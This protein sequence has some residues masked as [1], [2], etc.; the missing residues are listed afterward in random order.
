MMAARPSL[1]RQRGTSLIEVLVTVVILATGLLGVAGLQSR[2]QLSEM[3]AYQ[4]TQAMI[5]LEDMSHRLAANRINAASYVTT[6]AVAGSA[7]CATTSATLRDRDM[8][9]WCSALKGAAEKSDT[10]NVG[11]MIG[12][13][14][15]V[16]LIAS[17]E[18]MVTVAWQGMAPVSAPSSGVSC[19]K[20]QYDGGQC[21]DDKCR[22]AVT[23]VIR[24]ASLTTT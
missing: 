2:L 9:E 23:T 16:Q 15:C 1:L 11:A 14:G 10:S 21:T 22:R 19:G 7:A 6:T 13:R 17:N 24:F 12:G 3:E 20:D 18:Y 5:L 4:R 8:R